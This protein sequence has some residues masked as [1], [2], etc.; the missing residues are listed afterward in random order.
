VLVILDSDH[1]RQHVAAELE[2]Y[3]PLVTQGSYIIATDGVMKD[4]AEVP[5][6]QPQWKVDNPFMAANDLPRATR[7]SCTGNRRG[8]P[9]MARLP[10]M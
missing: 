7:S 2:Y 8:S 3:A 5:R 4:I 9:T 10:K 1:T 6:A